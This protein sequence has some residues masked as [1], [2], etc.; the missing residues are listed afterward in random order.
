MRFGRLKYKEAFRQYDALLMPTVPMK[1]Q[2]IPGSDVSISEYVARAFEMV[3]NTAAFNAG[4]FP[5]M[6]IPC[7]LSEGLPIGMML[8]ADDFCEMTIY[9]AAHAFEQSGDWRTF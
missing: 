7:G 9:Q 6:S 2:Q 8:V 3:G 5:A 1:A 4:H